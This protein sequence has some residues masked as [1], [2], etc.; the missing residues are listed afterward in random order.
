MVNLGDLIELE[1]LQVQRSALRPLGEERQTGS[2]ALLVT[3]SKK[4][5]FLIPKA[6]KPQKSVGTISQRHFYIRE[7]VWASGIDV[8]HTLH[9]WKHPQILQG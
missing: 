4:R 5:N 9:I 7:A 3:M 1:N 6:R 8:F 2:V